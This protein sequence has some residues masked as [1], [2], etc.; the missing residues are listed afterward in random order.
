MQTPP[1]SPGNRSKL[2]IIQSKRPA[3]PA[4]LRAHCQPATGSSW[5]VRA[6]LSACLL[7]A[8]G[9]PS[10][11]ATMPLGATVANLDKA[12][13]GAPSGSALFEQSCAG[14][15]GSRGESAK[16]APRILGEGALPEYP[17]EHNVNADPAAGDPELLRLRARSRPAG[18]PSR[19]PFRTAQD[20][21][22]YVSTNMPLPADQIG[23]LSSEQ[24]WSIVNFMLLA[25]G[26]ALPPGGVTQSNASSVKL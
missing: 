19:D 20:L 1:R 5:L 23:S 6:A 15:H 24:Y 2:Q 16:S 4:W 26:V 11:C 7:A 21:Y 14:C 13:R 25:H 9:T 22:R 18:A 17:A 10:G 8:L 12:R 3:F